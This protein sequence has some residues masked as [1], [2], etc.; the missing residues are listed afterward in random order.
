[1]NKTNNLLF[2][3]L[4]KTLT[5][6]LVAI[7][8]A[9]T[10]MPACPARA[11]A[12]PTVSIY[13]PSS[14]GQTFYI[15]NNVRLGASISG[16]AW[17]RIL[18]TDPYRNQVYIWDSFVGTYI[19]NDWLIKEDSATGVYTLRISAIDGDNRETAYQTMV[20]YVAARLVEPPPTP[21]PSPVA[22]P[23]APSPSPVV[24]PPAPSPSPAAPPPVPSPAPS[25]SPVAPPAPSPS[26][27]APTIAPPAAAGIYAPSSDRQ[28]FY[29]G[30]RV[31]LGASI[32]GATWGRIK[33]TNPYDEQVYIWESS[34]N[35]YI[36]NYWTIKTG[37]VT[38]AYTLRIAAVG[39]GGQEA[40]Y[41]TMTIYVADRPAAPP[42]NSSPGAPSNPSP[43]APS[44]P[45]PGAPSN[46]SSGAP[47]NLSPSTASVAITAPN[48]DGQTFYAG[49]KA[50]LGA[51]ISG[52][53]WARINILNA[54]G[55]VVL[56]YETGVKNGSVD[57][58]WTVPNNLALGAYTLR[59]AA[60]GGGGKELAYKTKAIKISAKTPEILS[61]G[62]DCQKYHEGDLI[63]LNGDAKNYKSW[64]V[65]WYKGAAIFDWTKISNDSKIYLKIG[66]P[67]T[68]T[69]AKLYIY[70][71]P[72]GGGTAVTS[73]LVKFT[74]SKLP[75]E[76][77]T[78]YGVN[79]I[80]LNTDSVFHA[81]NEAVL[82]G[83]GSY[84]RE[85]FGGRRIVY[86]RDSAEKVFYVFKGQILMQSTTSQA[87]A[88]SL[89]D[90]NPY[91][92]A[93]ISKEDEATKEVNYRNNGLLADTNHC[94][95]V[96]K[97]SGEN[98]DRLAVIIKFTE[99]YV[100]TGEN[101][102]E[103]PNKKRK[104][105][106]KEEKED[107]D[108][109]I[110]NY[111]CYV[112]AQLRST[113]YGDI[114]L[115]FCN[116]G[117]HPAGWYAANRMIDDGRVNSDKDNNIVWS[118]PANIGGKE[119]GNWYDAG[120]PIVAAVKV[121][122]GVY[123]GLKDVKVEW[124][125]ED[126]ILAMYV[127]GDKITQQVLERESNGQ[128]LLAASLVPVPNKYD[129]VTD[130]R[131]GA[132]IKNLKF[133]NCYIYKKGKVEG[134]EIKERFMTDW[135]VSGDKSDTTIKQLNVYNTDITKVSRVPGGACAEV[136]SIAHD[137][138]IYRDSFK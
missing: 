22:P 115:V 112:Y 79:G 41:Q 103:K 32:S 96:Y 35:N 85:N 9:T 78:M 10:F 13:G 17:G 116:D 11:S 44:N 128:F 25:P 105:V 100:K 110:K 68:A 121:E 4:F 8:V 97:L 89:I 46:P 108:L 86:K 24:P 56:T 106:L 122:D 12:A 92:H 55:K 118:I 7:S 77:F 104:I 15:G 75:T 34:A 3:T 111:N 88:D 131:S 87:T 51:G 114:G 76:H 126:G 23:P 59:I 107:T 37:S 26:P 71:Q 2:K 80:E 39:N 130:F 43:G 48:N 19:Q 117:Y 132:Y 127:G 125:V 14:S 45:S 90:K 134:T 124:V 84:V 40:A 101:E 29:I 73:Q 47:S 82:S 83:Y 133:E 42:Q 67:N 50:K 53:T 58:T 6:L 94:G 1:M 135:S 113:W 60:I 5:A 28:T 21:S 95:Y 81:I 63:E 18:V 20:I 38:G 120:T 54:S 98:Y 70:P 137:G 138:S 72:D 136:I 62:S 102:K 57:Y 66:L 74:V 129:P 49:D 30:D 109:G 69:G 91:T 119:G 61:F 31:R 65:V 33:V 93:F 36:E 27:S 64:K 16:A 123:R 99:T 52:A